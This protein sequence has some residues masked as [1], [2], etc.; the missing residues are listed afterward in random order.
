MISP[1]IFWT[2]MQMS[3]KVPNLDPLAENWADFEDWNH[4]YPI[5]TPENLGLKGT[6]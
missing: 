1:F 2:F 4:Y 3:G 6:F 5:V